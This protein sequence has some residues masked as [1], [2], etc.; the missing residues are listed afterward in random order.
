MTENLV[1]IVTPMYKGGAFIG[2]TIESVM[3]QTYT[4]WEMI[5]VDDCSPDDGAGINIVKSFEDE[6]IILIASDKNVGSSGARNIALKQCKGR[7]IAFL[8]SDDLW[9]PSFLESQILFMK[10][11][12]AKLVCSAH[13]RIDINGTIILEP[14]VPP[15]KVSY[16][17]LLNSNSISML[18]SLYDREAVGE[19]YF[20]EDLKSM[21]DDYV[22]WLEVLKKIDYAYGNN[23]VLAQ[24][25]VMSTSATGNKSKVIIPQFNVYYKIEGLGLLRSIYYMFKWA[26]NA[27]VK[28]KK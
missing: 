19:V 7:Y 12:N 17:G 1:S 10:E 3:N 22:Y 14:F 6:R 24:Y 28:W 8:D 15:V 2:K 13:D 5:I 4:N 18:T 21:R 27:F 11:N 26:F 25:R 9:F 20:R 23:S 16:K